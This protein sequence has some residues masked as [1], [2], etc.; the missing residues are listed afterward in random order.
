MSRLSPTS[1]RRKSIRLNGG[2]LSNTL[3]A[4][5]AQQ[6]VGER[7]AARGQRETVVRNFVHAEVHTAPPHVVRETRKLVRG[8]RPMLWIESS[9]C[10]KNVTWE[11]RSAGADDPLDKPG[12]GRM[13]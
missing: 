9:T 12:Y 10:R 4:V 7:C 5:V 8:A 13:M 11:L 6:Q 1:G 3:S 2:E